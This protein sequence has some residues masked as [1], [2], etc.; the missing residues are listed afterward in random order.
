MPPPS[1]QSAV[2]GE[3]GERLRA[4]GL[5][6]LGGVDG[7]EF[8][9]TQPSG[10]RAQELAPGCGT[11]IVAGSGGS[12]FWRR[13][14]AAQNGGGWGRATWTRAISAWSQA[15]CAD[16]QRWLR[17][18]GILAHVAYPGGRRPLN[19]VQLAEAAGLGTVSPVSG[20]L[21]HPEYGPWVS[22]RFALL[23]EGVA[24]VAALPRVV[25]ADF[26][27]CTGCDQR[28]VQACPVQVCCGGGVFAFDRCASHR[29]TGGCSSGCE[30]RRA[31]PCGAE[32][33]HAPEEEAVRH[34]A[35][36]RGLQR[37]YGLGWW[38]VVPRWAR[39]R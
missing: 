6:V 9:R 8:D 31:C 23:V 20:W 32:H 2:L 3:L 25:G 34:A 1:D 37:H 39:A 24:E 15:V 4:S 38:Q 18:R 12:E 30:M 14:Q 11:I 36:L 29:H 7:R 28:C 19:F 10:R 22:F 21:L 13:M 17:G 35:T 27:P 16:A 5:N 33:R 26:Q